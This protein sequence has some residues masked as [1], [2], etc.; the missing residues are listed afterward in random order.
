MIFN[1]I[2]PCEQNSTGNNSKNIFINFSKT[3]IR[4]ATTQAQKSLFEAYK[5]FFQI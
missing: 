4:E 5:I 2:L 3:L 1:F